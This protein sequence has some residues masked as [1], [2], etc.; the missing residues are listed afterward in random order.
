MSGRM[1]VAY[2][3]NLAYTFSLLHIMLK[4]YIVEVCNDISFS[5]YSFCYISFKGVICTI[6]FA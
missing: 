2:I 1:R 3:H 6:N 5:L 4:E